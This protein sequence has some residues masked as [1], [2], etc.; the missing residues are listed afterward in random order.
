ADRAV[1]KTGETDRRQRLSNPV[2]LR[3]AHAAEK[4]G[5]APEASTDEIEHRDRKAAV[6]IDRLRQ[7]GD[8]PEFEA[9]ER[10]RSRQ[11]FEDA[12]DAAEQCRLAGAV[13]TDHGEQAACGNLAIEMMHR[14]VAVIAESDV[15]ELQLGCHAH[16]IA[17]HTMAHRPALTAAAAASRA[18]TVMRRI[19]QGAACA[20]CGVAG[21]WEWGWPWWWL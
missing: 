1:L 7:I 4:A 10:N 20:G 15:A 16:L 11:R 14:R 19:D 21:P 18:T 8:V 3:L 17:S 13:R 2:A 6:D 5:R 9:A 12:G